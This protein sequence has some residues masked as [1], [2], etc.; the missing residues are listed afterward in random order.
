MGH[1]MDGKGFRE[2][3][4]MKTDGEKRSAGGT[5]ASHSQEQFRQPC[6][7]Q[8]PQDFSRPVLSA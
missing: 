1:A 7:L 4:M 8:T 3:E 2:E 6:L 5:A